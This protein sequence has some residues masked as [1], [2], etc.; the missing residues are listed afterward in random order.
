MAAHVARC[1]TCGQR[2]Q[3][4]VAL[5][6]YHRNRGRRWRPAPWLLVA[7]VLALAVATVGVEKR[8]FQDGPPDLSV[9]AVELPY[10]LVLLN[11][12]SEGDADRRA[13]HQPYLNQDYARAELLL[14]EST[15]AID[16][17]LRG[18]SLYMLGREQ[19]ALTLL[20]RV[21]LES[22]WS[23]PARWYEANSL[24]RL[25]EWEAA[26]GLLSKLS[27]ENGEYSSRAT[28]L[29]PRLRDGS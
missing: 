21:P 13:A 29:L 16:V 24:I 17:F 3:V 27:A 14:G 18:V 8:L 4:I 26:R 23:D 25:G 15:L 11:N 10:P 28:R 20:R 19:K 5:Q 22:V 12:R 6:R 2:L 7:A 9:I 1:N